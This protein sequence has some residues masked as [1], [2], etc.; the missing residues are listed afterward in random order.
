MR[1]AGSRSAGSGSRGTLLLSGSMLSAYATAH[2]S[3][4]PA[5]AAASASSRIVLHSQVQTLRA[6]CSE[7][8]RRS[9]AR[10]RWSSQLRKVS[11][12]VSFACV[13]WGPPTP[14]ANLGRR[15]R[16]VPAWREYRDAHL[17]SVLG[18]TPREF[19]SRIL[20]HPDRQEPRRMPEWS[21]PAD[22]RKCGLIHLLRSRARADS[23]PVGF[24]NPVMVSELRRLDL[25]M[26]FTP[27]ARAR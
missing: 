15:S 9:Q 25:L 19:E 14:T 23:H 2:V 27:P 3:H 12:V 5:R 26:I 22:G 16:T 18:E 8:T 10:R 20:R 1:S 11:F 21:W 17:E 24:L 7:W 4:F 6:V 13:R